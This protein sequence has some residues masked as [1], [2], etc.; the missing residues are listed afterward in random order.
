MGKPCLG[1][2]LIAIL[3]QSPDDRLAL[4]G[5]PGIREISGDDASAISE[6]QDIMPFTQTHVPGK[7]RAGVELS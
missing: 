4:E 1:P 6:W 3:V 7:G 5:D 2:Y